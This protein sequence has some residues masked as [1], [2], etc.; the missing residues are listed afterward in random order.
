MYSRGGRVVVVVRGA[1]DASVAPRPRG[2]GVVLGRRGCLVVLKN[3]NVYIS[4][5]CMKNNFFTKKLLF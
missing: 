3:G 5:N 2:R 1:L 4:W